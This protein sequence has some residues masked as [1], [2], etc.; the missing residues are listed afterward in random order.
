M[1]YDAHDTENAHDASK[2]G[3]KGLLMDSAV[4]LVDGLGVSAAASQWRTSSE[5]V[6]SS[7]I[8]AGALATHT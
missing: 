3:A 1:L 8:I 4:H 5:A 7:P 6:S 2:R